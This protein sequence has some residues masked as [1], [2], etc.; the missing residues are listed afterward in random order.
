MIE[1]GERVESYLDGASKEERLEWLMEEYG[2]NI[3]R[4]AFTYVKQKQLAEDI[5]Q[6][7]FIKCYEKLDDFRGEST[8]KTWLYRIT[9]NKCKDQL[10]SWSYKNVLFTEFFSSKIKQTDHS[11]ES[12]LLVVEENRQVAEK[13]ISLPIKLREV[14]ILHYYEGLKID[15][16]SQLIHV[17]TNTV[18]SRMHRARMIL[19]NKMEG[20][21]SNG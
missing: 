5:A 4:L 12:E 2:N 3:I 18:K 9:V 8:Y 16:I 10:K 13:V 1:P 17:N 21:P 19:K 20:G 14:I 7:V 6:D 15:E 11:A